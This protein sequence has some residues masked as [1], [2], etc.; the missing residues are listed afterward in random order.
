MAGGWYGAG[1]NFGSF[2]SNTKAFGGGGLSMK[3]FT[4]SMGMPAILPK[5][6]SIMPGLPS[7]KLAT[8]F[9]PYIKFVPFLPGI[10]AIEMN[11]LMI[12]EMRRRA[13]RIVVEARKIAQAEAFDT[14]AYYNSIKVASGVEDGQA[15][16]RANAYDWK[17]HWIEWGTVNL[18]SKNVMT[19][20]AE[21]AGYSVQWIGKSGARVK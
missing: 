11:P 17:S 20:G 14:G 13:E 15:V 12:A 5:T 4:F 19:R 21:A 8:P 2:K 9:S 7:I 18:P 3:G 1:S 6:P 10:K 16:G